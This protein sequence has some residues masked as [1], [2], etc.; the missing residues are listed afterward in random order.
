MI[1]RYATANMTVFKWQ[2]LHPRFWGTWLVLGLMR[3]SVWLP[4]PIQLALGRLLSIIMRPFL[5]K[6]IAIAQ[7]N[8]ALCFPE[9]TA[10]QRTQVL[11]ENNQAAGIMLIETAISWWGTKKA[12]RKRVEFEG[13]AHLEKALQKG[14]GVI[15]LT[16]HFTSLEMGGRLMAL[17]VPIY[18][19][20]RP[21]KNA[22]FNAV[23]VAARKR[24]LEGL[25]LQ[26]SPRNMLRILKK[27]K[28][29]WYAPDQDYGSRN[30]V[31]AT[32]FGVPAA[33]ITATRKIAKM[34]GAEVVPF[35]PKRE[36]DG[37]HTITVLPAIV[38]FPS[39]D[40]LAD[41]QRINGIIEDAVRE[42]PAQYFWVHRRFKTQPEGKGL[43]YK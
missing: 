13:L 10:Q 17:E 39:G 16:G 8:I 12:L 18:A 9:W 4:R 36:K 33:T 34:S 32:F 35:I 7:R 42:M 38:D 20:F 26:D 11:T 27:N 1:D 29:V 43:L 31:Q 23:M 2:Y 3:L 14:K 37:S 6:R 22:L 15:L 28:V 21:M 5:G 19:M 41:A 24:A 30:S 40:D 25:V